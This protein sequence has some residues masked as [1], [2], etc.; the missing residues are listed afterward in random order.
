VSEPHLARLAA[1][2][3]GLRYEAIPDPV[4]RA[5]RYQILDMIAAA[6]AAATSPE[7]RSIAAGLAAMAPAGPG[8]ATLL[9][10][11]ARLGPSDAAL[12][13]A[14][15]SM[16]QDFDDI[17]W[18]GHTCHSA[19]FAPLAVAEHEDAD[20]RAFL[21]AVVAANEVAGRLGASIFLGPVNG[22]MVTPIHLVGAAAGAAKILGLDATRTAHAL[23]I[24]L[25]QPNF[26][27]QPGF[28]TPTSKLLAAATP[29][30][31][32]T[33]AA[34]FARAGMTGEPAIL[35][36]PRGFWRRF[37]F[38]PLPGM[39]GGLGEFWALETLTM[40]TYPGCH[41]F[42]TACAALEEIAARRGGGPLAD[43]G[44]RAVRI[45]TTK[46]ACEVT[47]FAG[48]YAAIGAEV[49][50][51]NVNFD[52]GV[53]AAIMIVAGRLGAAEMDPA[54]LAAHS[55]AIRRW[56]ERVT[57]AHD[58]LLTAKVVAGARA[59][60][61]GREALASLR[62]RDL[63]RLLR[64]YAEEYESR[65]LRARDALGLV[66]SLVRRL[67][68][69]EAAPEPA[70]DGAIPLYF[71]ARVTVEFED[72][73]RETAE[74]LLPPGSL[75]APGVERALEAKVAATLGPARAREAFAA[76]LALEAAPL[77]DFV[78]L[79]ARAG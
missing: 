14:A 70:A 38:L 51:V 27:L 31:T 61:S 13:N 74:I 15:Y 34:Y 62:L 53:T 73:A 1:W 5:A 44:A 36:A 30:A 77:A 24:A 45:E 2:V 26:A 72:G 25:A 50:P 40:K 64:R 37:A 29:T 71:P 10:T 75:A 68:A 52:L 19:V 35:E 57:V 69:P 43:A 39:L 12:G 42:Q 59:V 7:T 67:R 78:R 23:A 18:M 16:A 32:G 66:R 8:R 3:A 11:G 20:A 6:H 9:A 28:M 79:V 48:D 33:H 17:I 65:L 58:P 54:W 76:G 63:P 60:A 46:L 4:R 21:T 49:T 22:Q 56:R 41:Y 47:R 55:P